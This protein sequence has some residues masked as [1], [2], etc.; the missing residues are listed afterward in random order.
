MFIANVLAI[1]ISLPFHECAHA[2]MA[3]LLGDTTAKKQGRLSLNPL[4]HLDIFGFLC[5]TFIGFGWAKPV[6][7]NSR[8]FAKPK[9]DM[10]LVALAGPLS[11]LLLA[12]IGLCFCRF[13]LFLKFLNFK[14]HFL[15]WA[16]FI[17]H[18][19][20]MVNLNLAVFNLIPIPPLDGSRLIF[21][22]ISDRYYRLVLFLETYGGYFVM[23]LVLTDRFNAIISFFSE[24]LFCV[25]NFLI[26]KLD[27]FELIFILLN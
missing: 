18:H 20:S 19:F 11:N 2:Y 10:T 27:M 14:L 9:R 4:S 26:D 25:F 6:P 5:L 8:N 13:L 17:F 16:I 21:N 1:V 24:N 7:I 22:F 3:T 15:I 12:F 23:M